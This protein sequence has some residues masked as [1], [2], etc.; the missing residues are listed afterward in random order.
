MVPKSE[1]G[2][3][4]ARFAG[5]ATSGKDSRSMR[6][7]KADVGAALP[8][9]DRRALRRAQCIRGRAP[10]PAADHQL[11]AF[12]AALRVDALRLRVAV[13]RV[14]I[15]GELPDVARHVEQAVRALAVFESADRR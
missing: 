5:E 2:R 7:A 11:V 9:F 6:A 4:I 12:A 13:A 3:S 14:A 1:R 10:G 8:C 15:R